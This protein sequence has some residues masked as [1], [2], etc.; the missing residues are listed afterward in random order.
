MAKEWIDVVDTAVKI[1]L[2]G[3]ITGVFTY[4]G[5][6]FNRKSDQTQFFIEH[7]IKMLELIS[8]DVEEYF[9]AW[10]SAFSPVIAASKQ[11]PHDEKSITYPEKNM[12]LIGDRDDLLR[13]VW[14]KKSAVVSKLRLLQAN[15]AVNKFRV[16][17][18]LENT[19]RKALWFEATMMNYNQCVKYREDVVKAQREFSQELAD[20]YAKFST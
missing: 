12:K 5:V 18:D 13:D 15:E 20:F 11:L 16:C 7:Q 1:G 17:S 3:L 8:I 6:K 4:L 14:C 2:G 19:L 10:N 9:S